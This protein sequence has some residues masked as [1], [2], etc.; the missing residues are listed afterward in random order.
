MSSSSPPTSPPPQSNE[1]DFSVENDSNQDAVTH[2]SFAAAT[3]VS[4]ISN[5]FNSQTAA[6]AETVDDAL[7]DEI[8]GHRQTVNFIV[9]DASVDWHYTIWVRVMIDDISRNVKRN[10]ND[11]ECA[12]LRCILHLLHIDDDDN[13]MSGKVKTVKMTGVSMPL[14]RRFAHIFGAPKSFSLHRQTFRLVVAIH[15]IR[16]AVLC[17]TAVLRMWLN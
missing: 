1:L 5:W 16:Y 11:S 7:T 12:S 6:K 15:A 2:T 17:K 4:Y 9:R 13:D 3:A 10:V 8:I 14:D